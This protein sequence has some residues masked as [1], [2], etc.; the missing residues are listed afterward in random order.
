MNRYDLKSYIAAGGY[1]LAVL[2]L[3]GGLAYWGL[4]RAFY[5]PCGEFMDHESAPMRCVRRSR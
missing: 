2:L 3:I 1:C 4:Y 5:L